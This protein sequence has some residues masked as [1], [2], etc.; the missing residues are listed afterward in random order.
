MCIHSVL[1][2]Y[3]NLNLIRHFTRFFCLRVVRCLGITNVIN[4]TIVRM[5]ETN[6]TND[7]RTLIENIHMLVL[8]CDTLVLS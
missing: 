4:I 8:S 5:K 1:C 3:F 6:K 7:E 2:R